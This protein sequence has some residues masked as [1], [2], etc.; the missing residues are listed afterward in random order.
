MLKNIWLH[1]KLITKHRWYVFKLAYKAGI[2]FRGFIHDLSKYS[3]TE[4]L[5][6]AKYYQ[7][8]RSPINMARQEKGYSEAWLHHKGR[9]KHHIEYWYD[10]NIKETPVIPYKYTIE[11]LCDHVAAGM[12]YKGKEWTKEYTLEYWNN[13]DSTR[14]L[15]NPKTETFLTKMKEEL[16]KEGIDKVFNKKYLK[17]K[18]KK[19]CEG[20]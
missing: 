14:K 6:S 15:Y 8:N 13:I 18:F 5:E 7:G 19:Y 20:Q 2:P 9:N 16:A 1:F 10:W 4:F 12:V 11:M 17:N 3:P